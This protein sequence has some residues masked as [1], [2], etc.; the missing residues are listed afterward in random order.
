MPVQ[1][2]P[3]VSIFM[4]LTTKMV[5]EKAKKWPKMAIFWPKSRYNGRVM[6]GEVSFYQCLWVTKFWVKFGCSRTP[7]TASA[8]AQLFHSF[9]VYVKGASPFVVSIWVR[10]L[11]TGKTVKMWLFFLR[12]YCDQTVWFFQRF[13]TALKRFCLLHS[14]NDFILVLAIFLI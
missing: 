4:A 2:V 5:T 8:C 14:E 9:T 7:R 13:S 3:K 10:F 12:F 6:A 1:P 11:R